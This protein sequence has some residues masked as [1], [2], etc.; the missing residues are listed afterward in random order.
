M[1]EPTTAADRLFALIASIPGSGSVDWCDQARA[2][3]AEHAVSSAGVVQLPPTNQAALR[4][5]VAK[6]LWDANGPAAAEDTN[7]DA[8]LSVLP[9]PVD[10]AAV[11]LE[12]ADALG[13]M[14]YDTDSNDYGY[15]TYRDA[16]NGGVMDGAEELRRMAAEAPAT[17][18]QDEAWDLPDARP[19]TTPHPDAALRR[20]AAR[21]TPQRRD[22]DSDRD[23]H[24]G[25][26]RPG[27]G[28]AASG[29]GRGRGD[30][31]ER[32][33]LGCRLGTPCREGRAVVMGVLAYLA[34]VVVVPALLL[35]HQG[36]DFPPWRWWRPLRALWPRRAVCA[37]AGAPQGVFGDSR[38]AEEA[39]EPAEG[40]TA[41]RAT[42]APSWA[43][44]DHHKDAA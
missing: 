44:T 9:A 15:D 6:A 8:V 42:R 18:E 16:W 38:D 40:R 33:R 11:L 4:Q 36:Q 5:R 43:R 31:G 1:T 34:L 17:E 10:R 27:R 37:P 2:L 25:S 35:G 41:P 26:T 3:L 20:R 24:R 13:R 30:R 32:H 29:P 14:D 23:Q 22:A 7:V 21:P 19:G 12:A 28:E 39:P